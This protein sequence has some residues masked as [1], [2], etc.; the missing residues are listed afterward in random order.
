MKI[1]ISSDGKSLND[2]ID[3]RFGRCRYF[4]I[5]D[6]ENLEFDAVGNPGHRAMNGAGPLAASIIMNMGVQAVVTGKLGPNAHETLKAAGIKVFT[7]ASGR[8]R[9]GINQLD[10]SSLQE[11]S[12]PTAP[13]HGGMK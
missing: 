8:V 7:G 9:D 12:G 13:R 2:S 11:A 5:V 4:V 10:Q 1:A 6:P 3:E